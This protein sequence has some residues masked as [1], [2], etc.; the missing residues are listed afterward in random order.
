[1]VIKFKKLTETAVIPKKAH[2]TDAA[3]DIVA[4]SIE[5]DS[6]KDCWVYGTGLSSEFSKD[7]V[8]MIFPR[9]SNTKK[10]YYL[11]NSVGIID[12]CYRGEWLVCF[13]SRDFTNLREPP[14]KVGDRIAQL[15]IFKLPCVQLIEGDEL[16]ES[17]R[18]E[19]GFG[20]TG[21]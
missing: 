7:Y 19:G 5:Y 9:S 16:S 11:P 3:F 17:D 14:Y 8:A 4:D 20:S 18:G 13:K 1:M 15:I 10:D 6:N 12:S 2:S 21:E